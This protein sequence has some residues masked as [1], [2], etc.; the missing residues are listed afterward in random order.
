MKMRKGD[1]IFL[2][3]KTGDLDSLFYDED[4]IPLSFTHITIVEP[5][6]TT[7]DFDHFRVRSGGAALESSAQAPLFF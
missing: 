6:R 2:V 4:Y 3:G 7:L 5:L 1:W